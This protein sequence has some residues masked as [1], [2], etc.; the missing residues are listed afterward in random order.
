M[1]SRTDRSMLAYWWWTVDR[2]SLAAIAT[3]IAAGT[4]LTLAASPAVAGRIGLEPFYFVYRQLSFVAPS[5]LVIFI[6]SLLGPRD[7]RRLALGIFALALVLMVATL[8]VGPEIKGAQ[9][10]LLFGPFS[11]QPSE[12]IK[13]AFVVLAAAALAES[14]RVAGFPGSA[15]AGALYVLVAGVLVLQPDF[16]QTLLLTIVCASLFFLAGMRWQWLAGLGGAAVTG[17]IV[18]YFLVPHVASRIDRFVNPDH[19]DSFQVNTALSAFGQGGLMGVGPG[20]G[21]VKFVLPDAHTDFIFAVAGEEFGLA[22]CTILIAL[23]GVIV[24]RA[25]RRALEERDH[26]I[27]LSA[28]GLA[29]MFGLQ[30]CINIAVTLSL[31]PAKGMTLPFV[32]Y[33]GSSMLAL[34]LT[35]G[36]LLALTRRRAASAHRRS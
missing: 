3:L 12:F 26:F 16:G 20:E 36:M 9:R 23:F 28:A 2:W 7:V 1:L 31:I 18:A 34:A 4:L 32:S 27:Q 5:L 35:T 15:L 17:A 14:N 10:W 22:A 6:V 33:G 11:L 25:L 24:V 13:P 19:G 29:V 21:S 8:F 30:A